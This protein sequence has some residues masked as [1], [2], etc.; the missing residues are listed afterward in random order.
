MEWQE[1]EPEAFARTKAEQ[2]AFLRRVCSSTYRTGRLD[3]EASSIA[4]VVL[5]KLY[6]R[7][8]HKEPDENIRSSLDYRPLRRPL[9]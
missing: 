8:L 5:L 1:E 7:Q 9:D 4:V 2:E 6:C 3:R